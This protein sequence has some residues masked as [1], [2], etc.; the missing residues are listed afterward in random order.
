MENSLSCFGFQLMVVLGQVGNVR[1]SVQF[2][3]FSSAPSVLL[4]E[5]TFFAVVIC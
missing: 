3:L 2:Q 4:S 1:S 5:M